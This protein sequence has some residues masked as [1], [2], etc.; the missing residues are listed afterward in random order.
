MDFGLW[1][2]E[3]SNRFYGDVDSVEVKGEEGE[4]F[5]EHLIPLHFRWNTDKG[6]RAIHIASHFIPFRR[7]GSEIGRVRLGLRGDLRGCPENSDGEDNPTRDEED[8]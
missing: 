6:L 4:E 8:D 7:D 5:G 3:A 2:S 1:R